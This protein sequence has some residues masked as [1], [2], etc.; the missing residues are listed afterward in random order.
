AQRAVVVRRRD[1]RL[2]GGDV[3]RAAHHGDPAVALLQRAAQRPPHV[4]LALLLP[5]QVAGR[6]AGGRGALRQL[7]Q[8]GAQLGHGLRDGGERRR[9][10][11]AVLDDVVP[12]PLRVVVPGGPGQPPQRI[13]PDALRGIG[14]RSVLTGALV[15]G[16]LAFGAALLRAPAFGVLAFGVL[17]FGSG[18]RGQLVGGREVAEA[19]RDPGAE[20]V[21]D[22]LPFGAEL[23]EGPERG[24]AVAAVPARRT[25][26]G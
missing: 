8:P 26:G 13:E 17:G 25:G 7:R 19:D 21:P 1:L 15:L 24:P 9:P 12:P 10:A 2:Q 14:R 23:G 4:G 22:R 5:P 18:G 6:Q 20:G 16:G 11:A 3:P